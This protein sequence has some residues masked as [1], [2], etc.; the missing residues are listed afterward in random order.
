METGAAQPQ[1]KVFERSEKTAG[2]SRP[3]SQCTA[4][5]ERSEGQPQKKRSK[6]INKILLH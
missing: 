1:T 3:A 2:P 5:P 4:R 6:K